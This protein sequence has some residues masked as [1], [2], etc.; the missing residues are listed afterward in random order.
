[1]SQIRFWRGIKE[2]VKARQLQRYEEDHAKEDEEAN[3]GKLVESRVA[4]EKERWEVTYGDRDGST[5]Q[6]ACSPTASP[7]TVGGNPKKATT[8]AEMK[9]VLNTE[10]PDIEMDQLDISTIES[11]PRSRDSQRSEIGTV[12]SQLA[13]RE[14]QIWSPT[15]D[16]LRP[17]MA[18]G[19]RLS[20]SQES[21]VSTQTKS[22][23]VSGRTSQTSMDEDNGVG[24]VQASTYSSELMDLPAA[25][26]VAEEEPQLEHERPDSSSNVVLLNSEDEYDTRH[27]RLSKKSTDR[28]QSQVIDGL[29]FLAEQ[30]EDHGS[31][32]VA[33]AN[34]DPDLE[35]LP[36]YEN[37]ERGELDSGLPGS[38]PTSEA[39]E[40][41][42]DSVHSLV[43]PT[44]RQSD[45]S[46]P[47]CPITKDCLPTNPVSQVTNKYWTDAW[48][49][50]LELAENPENFETDF[51]ADEPDEPSVQVTRRTSTALVSPQKRQESATNRQSN[52]RALFDRRQSH[53][54]VLSHRLSTSSS[55]ASLD[56]EGHRN[57]TLAK[58]SQSQINPDSRRSSYQLQPG[59][60]SQGSSTLGTPAIP[61]DS[62]RN[63]TSG[64]PARSS[65]PMINRSNLAVS[66]IKEERAEEIYTDP[67]IST[68]SMTRLSQREGKVGR[69]RPSLVQSRGQME[70]PY[71]KTR[72]LSGERESYPAAL[73]EYTARKELETVDGGDGDN[74]TLSE[75]RRRLHKQKQQGRERWHAQDQLHQHQP[76][77][78][79]N[80]TPIPSAPP[81][82][83]HHS[84]S[85]QYLRQQEWPHE[86][87]DPHIPTR[88]NVF[89]PT[90]QSALLTSFR[91]S[92]AQ[93]QAN[94]QQATTYVDARRQEMLFEREYKGR[95]E[96]QKQFMSEQLKQ[97]R[98]SRM[99]TWDMQQA[100][101]E[102]MSRIQAK[103]RNH[104]S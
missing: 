92:M 48:V 98:E 52:P 83:P 68:P 104:A 49:K 95:A 19:Q 45:A 73:N 87:Y 17:G 24:S 7:S 65:T 103:A 76:L 11:C 18:T 41:T 91:S 99:G 62:A 8:A 42:R 5:Q 46:P 69:K 25:T 6:L 90:R 35:K 31:S 3:Y 78:R 56:R 72:P 58:L 70:T 82:R 29:G 14:V 59:R 102:H 74:L 100:H 51:E 34:T 50:K 84:A 53:N 96:A 30:F 1:M 101:R 12:P 2:R 89:N 20:S 93:D 39:S 60:L 77:Q 66:P 43:R 37:S 36:P 33:F 4:R 26:T 23:A 22:S 64:F 54:S 38:Y 88:N 71:G 55:R 86:P 81:P 9:E 44:S 13:S 75:R 40:Q 16:L 57:N 27:D 28:R 63:S 15:E 80:S 61:T 94:L 21:R 47:L 32:V 10:T 67:S 97:Q 79:Q 85:Q